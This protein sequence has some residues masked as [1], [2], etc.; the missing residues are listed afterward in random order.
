[1]NLNSSIGLE[2]FIDYVGKVD[3][4]TLETPQPE[5]SQDHLTEFIVESK[6]TIPDK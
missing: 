5:F 1:M 4:V 6:N 3:W 2:N